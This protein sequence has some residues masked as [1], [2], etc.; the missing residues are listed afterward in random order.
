[1]FKTNC[2][3]N[4]LDTIKFWGSRKVGYTA[5]KCS[6]LLRAWA[7]DEQVVSAFLRE[8][9]TSLRGYMMGVESESLLTYCIPESIIYNKQIFHNQFWYVLTSAVSQNANSRLSDW[10]NSRPVPFRHQVPIHR[11]Q[12]VDSV[13]CRPELPKHLPYRGCRITACVLEGTDQQPQC[14]WG[15]QTVAFHTSN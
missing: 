2:T 7:V 12:Q 4:F 14:R 6:S 15:E 11:H 1:M 5:P 13:S 9:L 8:Q 10:E 3:R